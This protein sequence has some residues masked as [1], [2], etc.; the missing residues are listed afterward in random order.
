MQYGFSGELITETKLESKP[1]GVYLEMPFADFSCDSKS[2]KASLDVSGKNL[3][4]S[5][6]G[7]ETKERCSV[8]FYADI[9]G[10][11]P[12]DY[13]LKVIYNKNGE[14]QEV[15]YQEFNINK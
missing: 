8:K 15:L 10:I 12:G 4:L 5:L 1:D 7:N 14:S 6:S 13:W 9:M 3:V 11:K 2:F